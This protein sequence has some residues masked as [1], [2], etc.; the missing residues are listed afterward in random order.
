MKLIKVDKE[1]SDCTKIHYVK[2]DNQNR[3]ENKER[4]NE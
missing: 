4:I 3:K 2:E 1:G